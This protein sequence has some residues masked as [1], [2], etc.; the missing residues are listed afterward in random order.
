MRGD[1]KDKAAGK[2][3]NSARTVARVSAG[4]GTACALRC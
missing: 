4:T 2:T 1:I 3:K